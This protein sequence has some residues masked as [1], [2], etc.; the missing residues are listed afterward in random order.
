MKDLAKTQEESVCF[1]PL[2]EDPLKALS[3]LGKGKFKD[4]SISQLKKEARTEI[5]EHAINE[6]NNLTRQNQSSSLLQSR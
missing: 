1:E 4:K 2:E 5:E 6:Y 3:I